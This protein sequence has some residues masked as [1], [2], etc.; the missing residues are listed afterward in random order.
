M[1]PMPQMGAI[2]PRMAFPRA[3]GLIKFPGNVFDSTK[4]YFSEYHLVYLANLTLIHK[5]EQVAQDNKAIEEK[6]NLIKLNRSLAASGQGNLGG[7]KKSSGG[8]SDSC[9]GGDSSCGEDSNSGDEGNNGNTAT[10]R[11]KKRRK[12]EEIVREFVCPVKDCG[13]S[14]G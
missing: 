12:K 6:I 10:K 1:N 5:I 11:R 4:D 3:T 7:R 14:Y 8:A 13:R 9:A 2:P